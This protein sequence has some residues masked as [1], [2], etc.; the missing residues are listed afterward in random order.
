MHAEKSVSKFVREILEQDPSLVHELQQRKTAQRDIAKKIKV[1]LIK[2][3]D[4]STKDPI[5]LEGNVA[6]AITRYLKKM[7][8]T[9]Y[10]SAFS[11][12]P[13][14]GSNF[15]AWG[16]YGK[17]SDPEGNAIWQEG[18]DFVGDPPQEPQGR[19]SI[20]ATDQSTL[21]ILKEHG[22]LMEALCK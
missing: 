14:A 19:N 20:F 3:D 1:K 8:E 13:I 10:H 16:G 9:I 11:G 2:S 5:K 6:V 4:F 12:A 15:W 17:A 18:D 7:F 21:K 22:Q